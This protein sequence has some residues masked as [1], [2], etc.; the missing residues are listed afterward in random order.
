MIHKTE[1]TA[2]MG[3]DQAAEAS[4]ILGLRFNAA[5]IPPAPLPPERI[6]LL[7]LHSSRKESNMAMVSRGPPADSG[8]NCTPASV[9]ERAQVS[10][11]VSV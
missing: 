11:A 6:I 5:G 1:P 8:W 10:Q 2:R 9:R 7:A 4:A 3:R